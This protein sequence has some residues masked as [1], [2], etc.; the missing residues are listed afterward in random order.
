MWIVG[1][2]VFITSMVLMLAGW[3]RSDE[4]EAKRA[5][6]QADTAM[7]AIHEREIA[8]ADRLARERGER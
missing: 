1:D 3:M 8:L 5:D 6:R 7:A 4:R 2:L